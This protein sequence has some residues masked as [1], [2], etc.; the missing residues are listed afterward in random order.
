MLTGLA[1]SGITS[2]A[3]DTGGETLHAWVHLVTG[4]YFALLGV[5]ARQGRVLLADDDQPG[6]GRAAVLSHGFWRR[7]LAGDPAAVGRTVRLNGHPFTIA[8]IMPERFLGAG[9]PAD[10]YVTVSQESLLRTSN[11]DSRND[12][13]YEWLGLVGR[14]RQGVGPEAA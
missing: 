10:V 4:N 9:L 3:I 1:A 14:L 6:G 13:S 11:R 2:A 5:D 7:A 12:R 8:G